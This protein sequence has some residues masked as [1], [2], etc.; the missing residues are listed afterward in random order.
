MASRS[1]ASLAEAAAGPPPILSAAVGAFGTKELD[2]WGPLRQELVEG[3][4]A[5]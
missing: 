1:L 5:E 4:V 2:L 3:Q